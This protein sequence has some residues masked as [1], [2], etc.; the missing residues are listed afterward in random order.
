MGCS[1]ALWT[2]SVVSVLQGRVSHRSLP[3]IWK[4]THP[5][6]LGKDTQGPTSFLPF[7]LLMPS[8]SPLLTFLS[9]LFFS[10]SRGFLA[11]PPLFTLLCL[12]L[13]CFLPFIIKHNFT[14]HSCFLFLLPL[15]FSSHLRSLSVLAGGQG[16]LCSSPS[17]SFH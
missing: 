8:L 3:G 17:G 9:L 12:F 10:L 14:F 6:C 11:S 7:L 15:P 5:S 2:Q 1:V 16:L 4:P 13:S